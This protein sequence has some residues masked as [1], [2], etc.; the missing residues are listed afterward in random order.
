MKYRVIVEY[1]GYYTLARKNFRMAILIH[2]I[3]THVR[4]RK[5]IFSGQ[6][7]G[8]KEREETLETQWKAWAEKEGLIR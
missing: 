4:Q 6:P 3:I 5:N 1:I 2:D 8:H 7:D